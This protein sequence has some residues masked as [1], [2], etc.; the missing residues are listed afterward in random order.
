MHKYVMCFC[1]VFLLSLA[2]CAEQSLDLA[3]VQKAAEQGD[4]KAQYNLGLM[5]AAGRGVPKDE[6]KA[7]E[8]WQKAAE[9]GNT[10]AQYCLGLMYADGLG[11]PKDERKAM[12]W[13]Q[14]AAGQWNAEAQSDSGGLF[15]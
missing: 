15:Y 7:V 12:E 11:V 13:W 9:Q 8:W 14:K 1:C 10:E 4:S 2:A 5:Y 3:K 6:P